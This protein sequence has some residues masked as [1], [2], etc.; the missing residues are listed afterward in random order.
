VEYRLRDF[1]SRIPQPDTPKLLCIALFAI[2]AG[3]AVLWIL[4]NRTSPNWDDAWYLTNSLSVYD[5]LTQQGVLG[6]FAKLNSVFGFKA[7]LI[8]ALPSP[9]YLIFGRHW[10]A[11]YLVN[12]AAMAVLF[13]TMYRIAERLWNPRVAVLALA[14]AGTMPLLYG[15][16]RWYLVEYPLAA[17][18]AVAIGILM[19][20]E[21]LDRHARCLLFGTICGFG[22]L[23]KAAFVLFLLPAFIYSWIGSRRCV[24]SLVLC[25][26]PCLILA[27]PW[28]LG[29]WRRTLAFAFYN[30]YGLPAA[31][32]GGPIFSVH[33][34]A[35]YLASVAANAVS[36]Y[37]AVLA[38]ALV[39]WFAVTQSARPKMPPLFFFWLLP[40]AIFVFGGS[41]DIR[42]I[43][44]ILPAFA[45]LLAA[46][47]D[48][49]LSHSKTANA[50]GALVVAYPMMQMFAVSFG[51]PYQTKDLVYARRFNPD[52]WPHDELL[53][54]IAGRAELQS[55]RRPLLLVGTDRANLNSN[56]V[57]LTAVALK[58]PLDV[59]TTAHEENLGALIGRVQQAEFFVYEDGGEPES[60]VFNP[61]ASTIDQ[62]VRS[63]GLFTEIPYGRHVPDG[64]VVRIF[65]RS[66]TT[67]DA[68]PSAREEFVI[69]FG[70]V[71]ALTGA[72]I[73]KAP[74]SATIEYRWRAAQ[75]T[76][77]QY[78]SFTH[79][80]D[81]AGRIVAQLDQ[82]LPASGPDGTGQQEIYLTLPAGAPASALRLRIGVYDPPSGTRLRIAPL[83]TTAAS[84]F[85]LADHDT[86]LIRA[87]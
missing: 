83:S 67:Q 44:P 64:G 7:P 37:Y 18:V 53:R 61:Y 66:A 35:V 40:F 13:A 25:A 34:I 65:Q 59:E 81:P 76:G 33:T 2:F 48:S 30:G 50:I 17:L 38:A 63:G 31:V 11:A 52:V 70:G 47:L 46:L 9:F 80:I 49:V 14:M 19:E 36:S 75:L 87:Y 43:A 72:V 41:K 54:M 68:A 78:W 8:A 85:G 21:S 6:F 26:T 15:L 27:L 57:E 16:A 12:I 84:R 10:H 1:V 86:A 51:V 39:L 5:S 32:Q 56:N 24:R 3:S 23:L 77:R 73:A 20:P 29:H 60:P 79:L 62:R 4:L 55:N 74:D 58:L 69:D 42:Y 71:V 82:P 28:Y 45:L 22:L